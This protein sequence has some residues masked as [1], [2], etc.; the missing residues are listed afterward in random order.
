MGNGV[1][2]GVYRPRRPRSSRLWKLMD[3]WWGRFIGVYDER[4]Q[5]KYGFLRKEVTKSG[6]EF[7][8]CGI[9]DF[10]FARV[11]CD[12][13]GH[14][15]LLAFSCKKKLCP[16]CSKKRQIAQGEFLINEVLEQVSH[17]HVVMG[18]PKRLRHCF[19]YRRELLAKLSKLAYESVFECLKIAAEAKDVHGASVNVLHTWGSLLDWSPHVHLLA[20]WG[21][22][23]PDDSYKGVSNISVDV[24]REVF[25]HKVF[26]MLLKEGAISDDVV[27]KIRSWH[28]SG[29]H[30]WVGPLVSCLEKKRLECL[31]QYQSRG[32]VAHDR[33]QIAPGAQ[34]TKGELIYNEADDEEN[35]KVTLIGDKFIK[36]HGGNK[37]V[38][39]PLSFLADLTTHIPK[40]GSKTTL[41]Y[42]YYSNT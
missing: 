12:G 14:E 35:S 29:F 40:H 25:E 4:F 33:L 42:G 8:K 30:T 6:D 3:R 41:Y 21:V 15:Y 23:Y 36:R 11:R 37:R 17:R 34:E 2:K 1:I 7:L 19:Y 38:W 24:I 13:C 27:E 18:I 32:L 5:H 28:H 9:L 31:G 26:H 22:F 10:G 20:A 39:D 16:S